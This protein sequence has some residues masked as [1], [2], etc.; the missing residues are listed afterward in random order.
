MRLLN[1]SLTLLELLIALGLFS[2][3]ILAF[4]SIQYFSQL[5]VMT[6][7]RQSLLQNE[8]SL[9]L[10]HMAKFVSQAPGYPNRPAIDRPPFPN[11]NAGFRTWIDRNIPPTPDRPGDDTSVDYILQVLPVNA[12]I[13]RINGVFSVTFSNHILPGVTYGL[14]PSPLPANPS[15]FY[16]NITN[17]GPT[18]SMIEVGLVARWKPGNASLDN[19]QVV[20]KTLLYA[21]GSA[22]H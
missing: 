14:M 13:C 3:V 18:G 20:M 17:P 4:T 8:I 9:A 2:V 16:I 21:R 11:N 1:K 15:G 12:L 7:E 22:I 10:E 19:P 5:H 6:A